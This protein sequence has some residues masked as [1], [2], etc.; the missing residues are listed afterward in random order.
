MQNVDMYER[1][2]QMCDFLTLCV[3]AQVDAQRLSRC[4]PLWRWITPHIWQILKIWLDMSQN[5]ARHSLLRRTCFSLFSSFTWRAFLWVCHLFPIIFLLL[6]K[7][8]SRSGNRL[9][10]SDF[11]YLCWVRRY[12]HRKTK[13]TYGYV[14]GR[15]SGCG[16]PTETRRD[17]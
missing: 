15:N 11:M 17:K 6:S 4:V 3:K 14:R 10:S 9:Q 12:T 1:S 2:I 7:V 13:N 16:R 8:N 5:H